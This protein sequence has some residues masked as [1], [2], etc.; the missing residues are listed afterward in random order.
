MSLL[1][2][3][4]ALAQIVRLLTQPECHLLTLTGP[5]GTGKTHL[6][7]TALA[8]VLPWFADGVWFVD[9]AI[10]RLGS[11]LRKEYSN[12]SSTIFRGHDQ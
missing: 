7:L 9:L 8:E 3:A 5:G 1:G 2:R 11:S 6:A 10:S 12:S 4:V